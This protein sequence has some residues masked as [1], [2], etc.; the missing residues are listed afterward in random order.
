[1][2]SLGVR[3]LG[4]TDVR[5]GQGTFDYPAFPRIFPWVEWPAVHLRGPDI[6]TIAD[7]CAEEPGLE[8]ARGGEPIP[9]DACR[10]LVHQKYPKGV[11]DCV[12]EL[13][14][15]RRFAG[16]NRESGV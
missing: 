15:Y 14:S 1:M 5:D 6:E 8:R 3:T 10:S 13:P 7:T 2:L 4:S 9:K 16:L 12:L 11:Q